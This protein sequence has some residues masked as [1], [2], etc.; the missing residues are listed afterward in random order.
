MMDLIPLF[1]SHSVSE[2]GALFFNMKCME[3]A[4]LMINLKCD[5]LKEVGLK[6]DRCV[7]DNYNTAW[8]I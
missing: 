1:R 6:G 2:K 4:W 8:Y 5:T 3:S 7:K